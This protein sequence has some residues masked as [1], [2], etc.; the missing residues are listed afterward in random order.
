M[1]V[2]Q[3]YKVNS[4]R[5]IIHNA[6]QFFNDDVTLD[7]EKL[8]RRWADKPIG[9]LLTDVTKKLPPSRSRQDDAMDVLREIFITKVTK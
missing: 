5:V 9:E 6:R 3:L 2:N 8:N 4:T 1:K 7:N